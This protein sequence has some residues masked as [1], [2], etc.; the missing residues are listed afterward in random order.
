MIEKKPK[1]EKDPYEKPKLNKEGE[2]KDITAGNGSPGGQGGLKMSEK[3]RNAK[4]DTYKKPELK[5]EGQLTDITAG[6]SDQPLNTS[7]ANRFRGSRP[8]FRKWAFF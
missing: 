6:Q 4:K 3:N 8:A 7:S 2:F 5:K 1:G